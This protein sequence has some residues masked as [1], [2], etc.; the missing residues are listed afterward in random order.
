M[1]VARRRSF[2]EAAAELRTPPSTLSRRI[3]SLETATGQRLLERTSRRVS[4][5][6]EGEELVARAGP[7]LDEVVRAADA[8][9]SGIRAPRGTVRV[10]APVVSGAEW[11]SA[12]LLRLAKRHPDLRIELRLTN[13]VIGLVDARID[14]AVRAG[15]L[16]PSRFVARRLQTFSY[17]LFASA[18]FVERHLAGVARVT[19]DELAALPGI[20]VREGGAWRLKPARGPVRKIAP[21]AR[22]VVNDPRVALEAAA[23][24]LGVVCAADDMAKRHSPALVQLR[25]A[26]YAIEPR[27]LFVVTPANKAMPPR[28][29]VVVDALVEEA[30]AAAPTVR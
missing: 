6:H 1:A 9:L 19:T 16:A 4:L 21:A 3:A 17:S 22:F 8:T 15:P 24:G 30:R 14:V 7:L 12:A 11:V 5:T 18:P 26:G 20:L 23:E 10:T 27:S 28:T 25:C 29:R 13:E 2:I